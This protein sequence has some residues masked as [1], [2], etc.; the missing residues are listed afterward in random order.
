MCDTFYISHD[1]GQVLL[2]KKSIILCITG[3]AG[4]QLGDKKAIISD[5]NTNNREVENLDTETGTKSSKRRAALWARTI[6]H[7]IIDIQRGNYE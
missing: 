3:N 7:N 1:L 6:F 5:Y 4:K 2:N